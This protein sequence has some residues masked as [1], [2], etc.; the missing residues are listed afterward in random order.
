MQKPEVLS[1]GRAKRFTKENV[2]AFVLDYASR[3]VTKYNIF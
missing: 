2:N 1:L 3:T